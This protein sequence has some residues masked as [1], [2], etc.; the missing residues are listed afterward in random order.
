MWEHLW[1]KSDD[2][3]EARI[4]E[5]ER[6]LAETARLSELGTTQ[7]PRLPASPTRQPVN[8]GGTFRGTTPR[9]PSPKRVWWILFAFLVIGVIATSTI[10]ALRDS[11]SGVVIL[12]P[13]P[14]AAPMIAPSAGEAQTPVPAP[15][16]PNAPPA[17]ASLSIGGAYQ[18]RMIACDQSAISISGTSNT[19]VIT[20]HC[21]SLT[22][23]GVKNFVTVDA[24]DAIEA[25]GVKN[26]ITYRAGSPTIQNSGLQNVVQQG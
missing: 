14:S 17:G 10:N 9:A 23:S 4:R 6:P 8:Y 19:I 20:G 5:L 16:P 12:S 22:V 2:D 26:Q 18:T 11:R 1:V 3:P 21:A 7:T 15:P 24:V 13:N 25:S